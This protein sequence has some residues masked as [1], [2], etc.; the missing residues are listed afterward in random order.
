MGSLRASQWNFPLTTAPGSALAMGNSFI[1]KPAEQT[2]LT[3]LALAEI[4][5]EAGLPKGATRLLASEG[6]RARGSPGGDLLHRDRSGGLLPRLSG[7]MN[8]ASASGRRRASPSHTNQTSLKP[9]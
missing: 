5:A 1:L 4:C 3:A 6:G 9:Q 8:R 2:P 7:L